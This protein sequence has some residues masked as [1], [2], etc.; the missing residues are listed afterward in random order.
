MG[1][2]RKHPVDFVLVDYLALCGDEAPSGWEREEIVA[3]NL[4]HIA[5]ETNVPIIGIS[6][7]K[8]E[9]MRT[10][11]IPDISDTSGTGKKIHDCDNL[12]FLTNYI[13]DSNDG[14]TYDNR[15][16]LTYKKHREG[17]LAVV[18]LEQLIGS[19]GFKEVGTL[20]Q[21]VPQWQERSDL[22]G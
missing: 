10:G 1:M 5:R 11:K 16:T 4:K 12:I 19:T 7:V 2:L 9:G 17:P 6:S 14:I 22:N 20:G 13:S 8:K 18:H 3:N 21:V 15:R